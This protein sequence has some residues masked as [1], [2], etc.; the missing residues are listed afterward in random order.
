[1]TEEQGSSTLTI[2]TLHPLTGTV[3]S[4]HVGDS[5]FGVFRANGVHILAQEQQNGFDVPFQVYG[6]KINKIQS[7]G[8]G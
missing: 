2:L 5:V 8:V 3:R 1:M 7:G 4:F 6:G